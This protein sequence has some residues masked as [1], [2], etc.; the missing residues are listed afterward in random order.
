MYIF[1]NTRS[2]IVIN[3]CRRKVLRSG[4]ELR[5]RFELA[6]HYS[7]HHEYLYSFA[8]EIR[9]KIVYIFMTGIYCRCMRLTPHI[10]TSHAYTTYIIVLQNIVYGRTTLKANML[11]YSSRYVYFKCHMFEMARFKPNLTTDAV[12]MLHSILHVTHTE[13]P[14]HV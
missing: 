9:R 10:T 14:S 1:I 6:R 2:L 4:G 13:V 3:S 12:R 5:I 8:L 7:E 11:H